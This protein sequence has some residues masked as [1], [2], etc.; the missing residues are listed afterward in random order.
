VRLFDH[1]KH[2][3]LPFEV[4][5]TTSAGHEILTAMDLFIADLQQEPF[6]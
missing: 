2:F 4:D 1:A 6:G 3:S 5:D